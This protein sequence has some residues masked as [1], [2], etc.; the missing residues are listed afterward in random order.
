M[1][2]EAAGVPLATSVPEVEVL[3]LVGVALAEEAV[4]ASAVSVVVAL[5]EVAP[6]VHGKA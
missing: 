4:A 6:E 1:G 3:A 2:A 5:V